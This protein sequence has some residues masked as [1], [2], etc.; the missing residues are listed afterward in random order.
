MAKKNKLKKEEVDVSSEETEK[1]DENTN[2]EEHGGF[3]DDIDIRRN[4]GCGG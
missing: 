1:N 3:P 4:M 2:E